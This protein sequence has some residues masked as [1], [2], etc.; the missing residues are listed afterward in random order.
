MK[1]I[2]L[3]YKTTE[4]LISVLKQ[5]SNVVRYSYNRFL[6]N[7]SE[8]D[9]RELSKSMNSIDLLNSWLIQC[10]IKDGKAI[11]T[12]FKNEKVI[13]GG[14]YNL[15]N[16]LKNKITKDDYSLKRLS[17]INIQGEELK[18]G[19]RSFKLDIIENNQIIFKL[20]KN[21]HIELKLPNLRNNIKKELFKLQQLNEV[22]QNQKGYTYSIRFDLNNIYI[23][24]EELKEEPI[25]LNENRYLGIDLNPDSI[26]V[27]VLENEKVIYTQ[28]FSLKP[29]FNKILNEKLSSNSNRMK[30][31]QNKLKFETYEISKSIS[32]IAKQFNCKSVFIEDLHFKG[33]SDIKI[34]NRKNKNLW[35]RE[36][37][38][39]NLAKRLNILNI[40]LYSVN[41]VYSSF[42]GNL[43][44]GYT[45]A[46]NASIEIARRGFEYRIKKNKTGFYPTFDV[47]QQWKQ[48][49]TSFSDWKKF[50]IEVKNL[51]LKYRVSLNEVNYKFNV[52]QQNSTSKSMVLNYAF[53]D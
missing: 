9:I 23:S 25:K 6:E 18:Q 51:K 37:F 32:L 21:K 29:M 47:K 39:N 10:G 49:A 20:S 52:F 16:K 11:Q 34:S 1:T 17:P 24:F 2:K 43:M 12:R 7:K 26:G 8:K 33:S 46:I 36:L 38:I 5:Y 53:Y 4:D 42:I 19:N 13:F 40:K 27:S 45:D 41:P 48:M 31:F 3:P 50:F 44:Y 30:Y 28:E 22:K 35:K 14:K 15:I